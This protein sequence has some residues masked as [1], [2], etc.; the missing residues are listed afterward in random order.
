MSNVNFEETKPWNKVGIEIEYTDIIPDRISP[1]R[2]LLH[3]EGFIITHDASVE[4]PTVMLDNLPIK[5]KTLDPFIN[6][7]LLRHATIGGEI[8]SPI[9]DTSDDDWLE[10]FDQI[11]SLLKQFGER[12]HTNRGSI[13]VHVNF[14]FDL[15]KNDRI[16]RHSIGILRRA[17]ILAGYF[18]YAFFKIGAFCR[19]HRGRVM[20]YIYYRPITNSG[21][22]I[23]DSRGGARPILVYDEVLN[24]KNWREF[25]VRCGDI[26]NCEGRY[27]PCRYMWINFYNLIKAGTRPH[28]EFRV[29]NKTLR[30]DYLWVAVELCKKFVETCYLIDTN[31]IKKLTQNKIN[32]LSNPPADLKEYFNEL[33]KFLN[34]ED[35]A[36]IESLWRIYDLSPQP[37]YIDDRVW[38]HL[39][40]RNAV[41]RDSEFEEYW[42]EILTD[43]ESRK[44]RTPN[45]IDIHKL[46][47]MGE[48]I[49]P[50]EML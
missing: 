33:I 9:I 1:L 11:F 5:G 15:A 13:H 41:F 22:A 37:E 2:N 25:F 10:L 49:F 26:W 50:E 29:F 45:Y 46:K 44:V 48:T 16:N 19:P 38:S 40:D 35:Y 43:R 6:D 24:S 32:G 14:P 20:D 3:D 21:P 23:I 36:L 39:R 42:P 12:A 47:N 30:W 4:S 28:L 7:M 31:T 34:I 27:H 17:W 8:V 18:E